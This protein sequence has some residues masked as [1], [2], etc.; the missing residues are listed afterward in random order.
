MKKL[1]ICLSLL[2]IL[3]FA[4]CNGNINSSSSGWQEIQS[5]IYYR[6]NSLGSF[7]STYEWEYTQEEITQEE[8]CNATNISPEDLSHTSSGFL[9]T[10]GDILSDKQKLLND[11][12]SIKNLPQYYFL[13]GEE[14]AKY[15]HCIKPTFM[16]IIYRLQNP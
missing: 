15:L 12:N 9:I 1:C 5:I 6:N 3:C 14:K 13:Q 16:L 2:F 11:L 10:Y 4:G 7:T 8:F